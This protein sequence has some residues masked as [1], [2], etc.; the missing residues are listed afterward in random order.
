MRVPCQEMATAG[1][2]P[3]AIAAVVLVVLPDLVRSLRHLDRVGLPQRERVDGAG[4]P[5]PAGRAVTVARTHRVA[6]DD[7][8]DGA[9]VALPFELFS[10]GCTALPMSDVKV[11]SRLGQ[12]RRAS[13]VPDRDPSDRCTQRTPWTRDATE[14]ADALARGDGVE[15]RGNAY[16]LAAD[17]GAAAGLVRPER[18]GPALAPHARPVRDPRQRGDAAADAGRSRR[19]RATSAGSSA[20]RRRMRSPRRRRPT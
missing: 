13:I 9:A 5:A 11:D 3:L 4:R 7:E 1:R 19:S 12:V 16:D 14:Q 17:G 2:A 8:L 20:G 10:S 6:R 18:A 15:P